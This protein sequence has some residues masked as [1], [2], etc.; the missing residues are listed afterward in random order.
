M[1]DCRTYTVPGL[2]NNT[3][4]QYYHITED[5]DKI[6]TESGQYI[7]QEVYFVTNTPDERTLIV[8]CN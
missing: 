2:T 5:D 7:L 8:S 3:V 1:A 6:I 4:E